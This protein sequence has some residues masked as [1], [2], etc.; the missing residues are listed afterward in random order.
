MLKTP[1]KHFKVKWAGRKRKCGPPAQGHGAPCHGHSASRKRGK[2]VRRPSRGGSGLASENPEAS[3][4]TW[5]P[6]S[7]QCDSQA[8]LELVVPRGRHPR[9]APSLSARLSHAH[10][11]PWWRPRPWAPPTRLQPAPSRP[12]RHAFLTKV[13][14][15][16]VCLQDAQNTHKKT[17][18]IK[19]KKKK[20]H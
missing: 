12:V 9:S 14:I 15:T 2:A 17:L 19:K 4:E 10:T 1:L 7:C 8:G 20:G 18:D 16:Q 3:A 13:D 5:A 11:T 6:R